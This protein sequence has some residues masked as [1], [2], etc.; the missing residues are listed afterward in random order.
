MR[1]KKIIM[2]LLSLVA[3]YLLPR[4]WDNTLLLATAFALLMITAVGISLD[5]R[6]LIRYVSYIV[7]SNITYYILLIDEPWDFLFGWL[8][9]DIAAIPVVGCSIIMALAGGLLLKDTSLKRRYLWLTILPQLLIG[10]GMEF[11][12]FQ[13][14]MKVIGTTLYYTD[15]SS[16][17]AWQFIWMLN[18]YLP[19]SCWTSAKNS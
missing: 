14:M 12:Q 1:Q 8:P 19:L 10:I 5:K 13:N 15:Q 4:S 7:I 9:S 16:H 6:S 2:L 11:D 18:Y 17:Q 3:I